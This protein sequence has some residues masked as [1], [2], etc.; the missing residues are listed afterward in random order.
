MIFEVNGD[1]TGLR[2]ALAQ[3]TN[4][5]TEFGKESDELFGG[6]T[7]QLTGLT[8]KLSGFSG[9]LVGTAGALGLVAGGIFTLVS[10]SNDYV[11]TYNEVSK[12][13]GLSVTE[14]QKLDKTFSGLGLTIESYGDINRD[15]LDHLGDSARDASGPLADLVANGVKLGDIKKYST[16]A[17]GGIKALADTFYQLQKAGKSTAII[18]NQLETLGSDGSKLISVFQKYTNVADLMNAVQ[19]QHAILTDETAQKYAEFDKQVT[20]IST[21]F[22]LWKANAL[23]PTLDD[24]QML[25]DLMNKDWSKTDF[26]EMFKDFYYGGDNGIGKML[27]TL[28][29]VDPATIPGT[30]EYIAK[31]KPTSTGSDAPAAK[32]DA[33]NWVD[34][35]KLDAARKAA[36]TKA[37]AAAKALAAKKLQATKNLEQTMSQIGLS[38][39]DIRVKTFE[40]QQDEIIAKI[41]DSAKTLGLSEKETSNML[42]Q[43]Y[44]SRTKKYKDMIDEMIGYSDPNKDIKNLSE[45][46]AAV[47]T[48]LSNSQAQKLLSDQNKRTGLVDS[49]SPFSNQSDL[50]QKKSDLQD[51][52]NTELAISANL[53]QQLGT[54]HEEYMKRKLAITQKY[55]AKILAVETENTQAQ[56]GVMAQAAGDLGTML[57]GAAG[58]GSKAA[59]AAF[60]VQKGLSIAQIVMNIQTALS[61][62]L[63]TPFPASLA[64]YAQ[65]LSLGAS[66]ITTAKGAA[67]GQ[68]HSGIDE[69][70]TMSGQNDSTWILQAGERVV[71]KS[72]N[73]DLT[74][75]L[76]NQSGKSSGDSAPVVNA[77][78]IIQGGNVDDDA[79]FQSMLKK[80]QNSVTQA[81][82][83]SQQ[84]TQ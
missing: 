15:V 8:S 58:E 21:S 26:A 31:H 30:K 72:A 55:N 57:A 46:I 43:A 75:Y 4:S 9:G 53:N 63:A 22:Q 27:R 36:E 34:Q 83:N 13:T 11:K 6:L 39:G 38:E 14:L 12:T 1:V 52:M 82:R 29:G 80:H 47:G 24:I 81:V 3:G 59:Q 18:T 77:P 84:R 19:S 68:A 42:N 65:V 10:A 50:D 28:D 7:G 44:D 71:Q 73:K 40:R 79:K 17:D 49:T 70:P 23:G 5:I 32:V 2:K 78:L 62:A 76:Q 20:Q 16:Q 54:N 69:V 33:G 35:G 56:I 37:A 48:N 74:N 60:M 41:K 66:I 45:N 61:S 51:E 67:S 25:F 64:A